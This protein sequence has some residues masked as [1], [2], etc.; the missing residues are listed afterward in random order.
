MKTYTVTIDFPRHGFWEDVEFEDDDNPTTGEWWYKEL[1]DPSCPAYGI[2]ETY[3][4]SDNYSPLFYTGEKPIR[5]C[6]LDPLIAGE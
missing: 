2:L 4:Q 5:V 3:A 6:M 1:E